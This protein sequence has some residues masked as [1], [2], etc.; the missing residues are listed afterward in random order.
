ME[1]FM[2]GPAEETD[3]TPDTPTESSSP[4]ARQ[5]EASAASAGGRETVT[6]ELEGG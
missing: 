1:T 3:V 4:D 6:P 5:V 2:Y